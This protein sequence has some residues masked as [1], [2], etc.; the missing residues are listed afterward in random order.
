MTDH[1]TP[2]QTIDENSIIAERRS[3]LAHWRTE[4]IAYPNDFVPEHR[5]GQLQ[6]QFEVEDKAA[7]EE[8]NVNVSISGRMTNSVLYQ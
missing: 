6:K 7:V 8:H 1:I 5:A 3:K 2:E 4:G